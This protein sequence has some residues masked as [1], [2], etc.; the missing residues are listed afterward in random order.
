VALRAVLDTSSLIGSL[1]HELIWAAERN[2]YTPLISTFII[3]EFTR[4]WTELA[5]EFGTDRVVYRQRINQAI[6][7]LTRLA[8][9]V[10][11]T[12]LEGG[13]YTHWLTDPD[14]EPILATALVGKAHYIV[15][16]NTSD[17]PPG[18]RYAGIHYVTP[19]EFLAHLYR[20]HPRKYGRDRL[21]LPAYRFP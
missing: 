20:L 3:G 8:T 13:N 6:D 18:G 21:N 17:F 7:T 15:S 12:R 19:P 9:V 10:D 16:A 14:D 1:R 5:I 4:I 11:Y 2:Y